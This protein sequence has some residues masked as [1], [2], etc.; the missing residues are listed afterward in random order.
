MI[1][2]HPM[3][4]VFIPP[5]FHPAMMNPQMAAMMDQ[6]RIAVAMSQQQQMSRTPSRQTISVS[7]SHKIHELAKSREN[8]QRQQS[9]TPKTPSESV[10][11]TGVVTPQRQFLPPQMMQ[12]G[13]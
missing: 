12:P 9:A 10:S 1:Q 6:Q 8:Q 13:F 5:P 2:A 4:G 3:A 11:T 7:D